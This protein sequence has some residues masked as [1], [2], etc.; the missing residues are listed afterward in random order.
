MPKF[1]CGFILAQICVVSTASWAQGNL[2]APVIRQTV[3]VEQF[4]S[5]RGTLLASANF[6]TATAVIRNGITFP[7][8]GNLANPSGTS[9][10]AGASTANASLG[11]YS[12]IDPL[13]F[14][15]VSAAGPVTLTCSNLHPSKVYLVQVLHGEPRS[16]C[17][18]TFSNNDFLLSTGDIVAVP[19]FVMGNGVQGENPPSALDRAIVEVELKGITSFTY[20]VNPASSRDASIAGFQVREL[21]GFANVTTSLAAGLPPL[22]DATVAWGDYDGDK[23][24]DFI[25]SGYD[26]IASSGKS[27]LW[28]NTGNGF[29]N[30]TSTATPGLPGL[31]SSSVSWADY[32]K[33]G[34]LD[35]FL[36]GYNH[37]SGQHS[38]QLWRNAGNVFSDVTATA[39]PSVPFHGLYNLSGSFTWCD[40]DKDGLLDG[41]YTGY[42]GGSRIS[43]LWRNNGTHFTNVTASAAPGLPG[44]AGSSVAWGDYDNDGRMDFLIA[45]STN[46]ANIAQL[47]RNTGSGFT[48]VTASVIPGLPGVTDCC[49]AWGDYDNDRRLDFLITGRSGPNLKISQLWRNLGSTFANVTATVAPGL[50]GVSESPSLAWSDYDNDG[51]L[52]FLIAGSSDGGVISQLW[53]NTGNGFTNVTEIVMPGL[54]GVVYGSLAWGNFDNDALPDLLLVGKN[55][56]AESFAQ[57]WRNNGQTSPSTPADSNGDG[58][59]SQTE[60]AAILAALPN[61]LATQNAAGYY[62]KAQVQSLNVG[63]SLIEKISPGRFR[64]T[65]GIQKST[66]PATNPFTDS[67]L[68]SPGSFYQ[69]NPQGELEFE[70]PSADDAAF[71]R[72]EAR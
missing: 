24:L 39:F 10:S 2:P 38:S 35:F 61:P 29:T 7:P 22:K 19:S 63:A 66:N 11:G 28:R 26:D 23:R 43:W 68:A 18:G 14:S 45:G 17:A 30:V 64:L 37:I 52:D 16:C 4:L 65:L 33:D 62:A 59:V 13:F 71:F 25:F 53:K 12:S 20:R 1:L 49:V 21:S 60:F 6:G 42:R 47:W 57:L 5:A 50:P 72:V 48:N 46:N 44:V 69:I 36:S 34:D 56:A 41:L 31:S 3:A 15:E 67:S 40:Y 8:T 9:W 27:Q 55:G 58:T 70:F 54:P 51:R 32:D